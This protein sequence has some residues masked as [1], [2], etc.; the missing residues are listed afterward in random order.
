MDSCTVGRRP[1]D[2]PAELGIERRRAIHERIHVARF[3]AGAGVDQKVQAVVT[4]RLQ[5]IQ[6]MVPAA[7]VAKPTLI[8]AQGIGDVIPSGSRKISGP[9]TA[10]QQAHPA[11]A[12]AH[13][14]APPVQPASQDNCAGRERRLPRT[15]VREKDDLFGI[16]VRR[17]PG[18]KLPYRFRREIEDFHRLI[19]PLSLVLP[20]E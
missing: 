2:H 20:A 11:A 19:Q 9:Q 3:C 10:P 7:K 5:R 16:E 18:V 6:K 13:C 17:E 14:K 1:R 12:I 4:V 8:A 15:G